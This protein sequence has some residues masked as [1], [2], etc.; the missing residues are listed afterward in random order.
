MAASLFSCIDLTEEFPWWFYSWDSLLH[1]CI[2]GNSFAVVNKT[3]LNNLFISILIFG[4][5]SFL[6]FTIRCLFWI[7]FQ[8]VNLLDFSFNDSKYK[9]HKAINYTYGYNLYHCLVSLLINKFF[10]CLFVLLMQYLSFSVNPCNN[11]DRFSIKH[12]YHSHS[13]WQLTL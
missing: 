3:P 8:S 10:I 5:F 4:M 2:F 7:L 1:I 11:L 9:L 12:I 6:L 13:F